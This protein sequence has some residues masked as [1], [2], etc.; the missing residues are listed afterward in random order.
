MGGIHIGLGR[1]LHTEPHRF[2]AGETTFGMGTGGELVAGG[3]GSVTAGKQPLYGT[4]IAVT[5]FIG[6]LQIFRT[7][8]P[9]TGGT[10]MGTD[11]V[12]FTS[13]DFGSAGLGDD[14][15]GCPGGG[16]GGGSF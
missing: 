6:G 12:R 14:V 15:A 3:A 13:S 8:D 2:L 5:P 11:E 7:A 1:V 10:G 9:G 16:L 4:H